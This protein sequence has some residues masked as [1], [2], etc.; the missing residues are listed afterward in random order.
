MTG[1]WDVPENLRNRFIIYVYEKL[2][3]SRAG[4]ASL[5]TAAADS[6]FVLRASKYLNVTRSI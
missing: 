3:E 5:I 6:S 2:N 4:L 1:K